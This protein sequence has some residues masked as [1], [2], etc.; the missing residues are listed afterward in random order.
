MPVA[1]GQVTFTVTVTN[2]GPSDAAGVNV[3][4]TLPAGYTLVSATPSAGTWA[5]PTWA[6]GSMSK[7]A[8]ATLT[9]VATVNAAGPYANTATESATTRDP[10]RG[11]NTATAAP[12]TVM[13]APNPVP[14]TSP[15]A[16]AMVAL[17]LMGMALRLKRG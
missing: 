7:G 10:D 6:I 14:A 8:S 12:E 5:A 16:L 11:N 1:G 17:G 15:W 4:D 9:M 2:A 13:P 3:V